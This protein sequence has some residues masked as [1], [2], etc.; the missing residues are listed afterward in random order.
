MLSV[1]VIVVIGLGIRA[2]WSRWRARE[3]VPLKSL[4][5]EM[6]APEHARHQVLLVHSE[7]GVRTEQR[8]LTRHTRSV[9]AA[10]TARR[11]LVHRPAQGRGVCRLTASI[12]QPAKAVSTSSRDAPPASHRHRLGP[13]ASSSN[14]AQGLASAETPPLGETLFGIQTLEAA[15]VKEEVERPQ[16]GRW[17]PRHVADD[18]AEPIHAPI[19]PSGRLDRGRHIVRSTAS[20]PL[21]G[22]V[23]PPDAAGLLLALQTAKSWP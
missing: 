20:H 4:L 21:R 15:D 9:A 1:V 3:T 16:V 18:V 22:R 10:C 11:G 7:A 23:V 19:L 13:K 2:G 8:C 17:Q 6:T 5:P 12:S 14:V